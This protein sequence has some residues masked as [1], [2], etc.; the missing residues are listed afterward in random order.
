MY[1]IRY[2]IRPT[3]CVKGFEIFKKINFYPHKFRVMSTFARILL[4]VKFVNIL[5]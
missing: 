2:K 3:T 4:H 5:K 1:I